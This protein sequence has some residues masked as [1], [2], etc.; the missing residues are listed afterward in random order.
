MKR[1]FG[2]L[3]VVAL[4][5]V[6]LAACSSSDSAD[7]VT[8]TTVAKAADGG[9]SK[10]TD[11]GSSKTSG[12]DSGDVS[13]GDLTVDQFCDKAK[14]LADVVRNASSLSQVDAQHAAQLSK[15]LGESAKSLA[16]KIMQDPSLAS[17]YSTCARQ[18]A[19]AATNLPQG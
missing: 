11:S 17:K 19:E 4:P 7:K 6:F 3:L 14:E 16:A 12:S 8:T 2:L 5:A 1:T 13:T 10:T 9:N 15:E 18:V